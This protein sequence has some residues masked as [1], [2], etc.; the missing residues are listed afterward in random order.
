MMLRRLSVSF[1]FRKAPN[2][3]STRRNSCHDLRATRLRRKFCKY[4]RVLA[5]KGRKN[6][7]M[8]TTRAS[9]TNMNASSLFPFHCVMRDAMATSALTTELMTCQGFGGVGLSD[10][11]SSRPA[12]PKE[13]LWLSILHVIIRAIDRPRRTL[14]RTGEGSGDGAIT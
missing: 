9:A 2:L 1:S 13:Y 4:L 7:D 3:F 12:P 11:S 5:A 14:A 6:V 10:G 8:M